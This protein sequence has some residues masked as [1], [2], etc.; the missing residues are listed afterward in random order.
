M[1]VPEIDE[2]S[3]ARLVE[4]PVAGDDA[5]DVPQRHPEQDSC[6]E[7]SPAA[8]RPWLPVRPDPDLDAG[9][10]FEDLCSL[11]FPD[12]ERGDPDHRQH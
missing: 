7:H 10:R 6:P 9:H 3:H 4:Q 5:G 1:Q 11:R 8:P 12:S 2:L